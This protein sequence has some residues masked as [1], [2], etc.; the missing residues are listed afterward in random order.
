MI[1]CDN[2]NN[3][4]HWSCLGITKD[5]QEDSW[6]CSACINKQQQ[7]EMKFKKKRKPDEH[8]EETS[9]TNNVANSKTNKIENIK[10]SSNSSKNYDNKHIE[11]D[12]K[13]SSKKETVR[14]NMQPSTSFKN[15][16]LNNDLYICPGCKKPDDGS[17]MIGCDKLRLYFKFYC[18]LILITI[19]F[20]Y[21]FI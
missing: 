15:D 12:H 4:F 14:D 13:K 9:H 21:F 20:F 1:G 8:Q 2:C 11:K 10:E 16:L 19:F 6:F 5:P 3:W 7:I 18:L 17:P